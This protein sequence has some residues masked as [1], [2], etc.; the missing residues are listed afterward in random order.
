[1]QPAKS[2]SP[3]KEMKKAQ[4][5]VGK[6]SK[7]AAVTENKQSARAASKGPSKDSSK[8]AAKDYPKTAPKR[9]ATEP[10]ATLAGSKRAATKPA[11][12]L[13]KKLAPH[14]KVTG[15]KPS[16]TIHRR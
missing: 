5:S 9:S 13:A 7:V 16:K 6:A 8:K 15:A 14:L 1:M 10:K 11:A 12:K 4:T 3:P 2:T